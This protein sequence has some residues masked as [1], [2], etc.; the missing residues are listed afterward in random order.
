M[1]DIPRSHAQRKEKHRLPWEAQ[2]SGPAHIQ[3]ACRLD[4]QHRQNRKIGLAARHHVG[5][6]GDKISYKGVHRKP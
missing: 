3:E 5:E 6:Q 1:E 4:C 2:D